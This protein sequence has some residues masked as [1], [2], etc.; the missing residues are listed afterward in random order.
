MFESLNSLV[1]WFGIYFVIK[2]EFEKCFFD[3]G[4]VDIKY[5]I[6]FIINSVFINFCKNFN[7]LFLYDFCLIEI[8]V[9]YFLYVYLFF[10]L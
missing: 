5:F 10:N 9:G 8:N 3:C 1:G 6:C 2:E 4:L 7:I